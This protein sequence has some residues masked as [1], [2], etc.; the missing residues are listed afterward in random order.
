MGLNQ[1]ASKM[2]KE[3]NG[4]EIFLEKLATRSEVRKEKNLFVHD[5]AVG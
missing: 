3:S 5:V 2:R 1:W 4:A